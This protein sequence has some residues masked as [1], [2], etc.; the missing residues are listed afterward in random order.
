MQKKAK[1]EASKSLFRLA[2]EQ[3]TVLKFQE[4]FQKGCRIGLKETV[5]I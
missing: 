2:A 1:T 4:F 3:I 5:Q